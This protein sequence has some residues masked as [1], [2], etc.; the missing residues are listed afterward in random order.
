MKI[1][2]RKLL[3]AL[4]KCDQSGV[5]VAAAGAHYQTTGGRHAHGGVDG[6]ALVNCREARAVAQMGEKDS[7]AG[8]AWATDATQL[9]HQIL[10]RE[11]VKAIAA[12]ADRH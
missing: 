8:F 1:L 4:E 10:V 12:N 3:V 7:A 2:R 11:P 6:P 9:A 5:D